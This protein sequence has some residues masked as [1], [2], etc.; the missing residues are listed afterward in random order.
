MVLTVFFETKVTFQ[1]ESTFM[2]SLYNVNT[3]T[4]P[5][6]INFKFLDLKVIKDVNSIISPGRMLNF[7]FALKKLSNV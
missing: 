4:K 1:P 7:C 5:F 2:F 6:Y 3:E